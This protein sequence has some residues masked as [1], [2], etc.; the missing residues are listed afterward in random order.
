MLRQ[1]LSRFDHDEK[2]IIFVG[3]LVMMISIPLREESWPRAYIIVFPGWAY[4]ECAGLTLYSFSEFWS[5]TLWDCFFLSFLNFSSINALN[6]T[7]IRR[8]GIVICP[9]KSI[10]HQ[11]CGKAQGISFIIRACPERCQ[12]WEMQPGYRIKYF[13][14]SLWTHHS[15]RRA[16]TSFSWPDN[17]Y[18]HG[19]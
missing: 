8:N 1:E 19:P 15:R 10:F 14:T 6:N 16:R 12:N 3:S 4:S 13:S 9:I 11:R 18:G 17:F 2:K 7:L 5:N